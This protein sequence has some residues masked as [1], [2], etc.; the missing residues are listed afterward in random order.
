MAAKSRPFTPFTTLMLMVSPVKALA[1]QGLSRPPAG[2]GV[3]KE[4]GAG[5]GRRCFRHSL[6]PLIFQVPLDRSCRR[7]SAA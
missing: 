7:P 6:S 1:V 3:Q 4:K 5:K 2:T